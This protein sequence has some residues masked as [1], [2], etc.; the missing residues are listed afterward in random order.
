MA[1][2]TWQM[3][4][5]YLKI[6]F[7][8]GKYLPKTKNK[9]KKKKKKLSLHIFINL[10]MLMCILW[11]TIY[12]LSF[13]LYVCLQDGGNGANTLRCSVRHCHATPS[14]WQTCCSSLSLCQSVSVHFA[15]GN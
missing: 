12:Q 14:L 2:K 3:T 6:S 4:V 5:P 13:L 10:N 7:V 8:G 9:I 1:L 15:L 11:V